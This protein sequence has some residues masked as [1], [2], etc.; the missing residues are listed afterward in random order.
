MSLWSAVFYPATFRQ[1]FAHVAPQCLQVSDSSGFGSGG[2]STPVTVLPS[3]DSSCYNASQPVQVPWFFNVDPPGGITQCESVR[4][5]WEAPEVNGYATPSIILYSARSNSFRPSRRVPPCRTANF[6][7]TIPGGTSFSIPQGALS[8]NNDT[9]T[10]FNWTADI[11]GGTN[12]L[13]IGSDGRGMGSG[14]SAGFTVSYST[15]GS[16]LSGSSPSSTAGNPA[17]G[18]YPTSTS[19]PSSSNG[20]HSSS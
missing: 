7:G 6:Y 9:G 19:E 2:A 16:C 3:S 18:S 14:G 8:T 10:G 13:L 5:W 11:T 1:L 17:G 4:L 12:V 20:N 15:N